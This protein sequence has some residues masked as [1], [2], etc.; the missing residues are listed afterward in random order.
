MAATS[1]E[2]LVTEVAGFCASNFEKCPCIRV[3]C[4][5]E[6]HVAEFDVRVRHSTA[7]A[8][9]LFCDEQLLER[10]ECDDIVRVST[11]QVGHYLEATSTTGG[12]G[13]RQGQ[14]QDFL[15]PRLAFC[16]VAAEVPDAKH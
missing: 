2:H 3:R 4:P 13:S 1:F 5:Q 11:R 12:I 10:L 7:V 8:S 16:E 14:G 6:V 9:R 15:Q